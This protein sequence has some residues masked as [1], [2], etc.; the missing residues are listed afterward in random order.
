MLGGRK[1]GS[2]GGSVNDIIGPLLKISLPLDSA[3]LKS[4]SG[5]R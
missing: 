5:F 1:T 4:R 3:L 2:S